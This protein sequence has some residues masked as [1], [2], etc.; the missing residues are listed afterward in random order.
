MG[1]IDQMWDD[2]VAGP[3]PE[4]D[5]EQFKKPFAKPLNLKAIGEGASGSM[6][7]PM[8]PSTPITPGSPSTAK[9][10]NVWRSVF[11]PGTNPA[12]RN[13]GASDYF[14]KPAPNSPSVYDWLYNDGTRS[15]HR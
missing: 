11:S 10:E 12:T 8:S 3:Q 1:L 4:R 2:V 14:D 5:Q 9:R 15:K 13:I 7:A 6:S